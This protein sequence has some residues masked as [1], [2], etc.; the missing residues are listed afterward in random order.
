MQ[1]NDNEYKDKTN[2]D[3]QGSNQIYTFFLSGKNSFEL[4]VGTVDKYQIIHIN[5]TTSFDGFALPANDVSPFKGT[6]Y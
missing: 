2:T 3:L 5:L 1:S 6:Y 4:R